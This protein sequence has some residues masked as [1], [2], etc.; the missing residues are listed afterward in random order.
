MKLPDST[1]TAEATD[2]LD[3]HSYGI[4][5]ENMHLAYQ[6]FTQYS[7]PISSI[8]REV[9]SNCVDAHDE[10]RMIRDGDI[11][12]DDY[13]D[14]ETWDELKSRLAG[15]EE[16]M[17]RI[18]ISEKYPL[19]DERWIAFHDKG[20]GLSPNR[21]EKIYSRFF[22]SNKRD[23]NDLIGAF[24][25]GSKSPLSYCD[26]FDVI[27]RYNGIEYH[28]LV[29]EEEHAPRIDL[30][31]KEPTEKANG[32][33]VRV[34]IESSRDHSKF[35][36]ACRKQLA[37]FE[38]LYF[39]GGFTGLG[40]M[41]DYTLH[42]G[43]N[44]MY[45]P[46]NSFDKLHI[47]L[48]RV[49]YP[50]NFDVL[51]DVDLGYSYKSSGNHWHVPIALHFDV[52]ELDIVWNRESIEYTERTQQK[53]RDKMK[54]VVSEYERL[55]KEKYESISSFPEWIEA[56][57]NVSNNYMT[58]TEGTELPYSGN[59]LDV[60][61]IPYP[62]YT[63]H[64]DTLPSPFHMFEHHREIKGGYVN[65]KASSQNVN[66]TLHNDAQKCFLTRKHLKTQRNK[67]IADALGHQKFHLFK[68][69]S[70]KVLTEDQ[71]LKRKI[72]KSLMEGPVEEFNITGD[73]VQALLDFQQEAINYVFGKME[74]YDN[75]TVTEA[76][77]KKLREE[78]RRKREKKQK[79]QESGTFPAKTLQRG[80]SWRHDMTWKRVRPRWKNVLRNDTLIV[81]GH[82][83]DSDDL[84]EVGRIVR[85]MDITT[86]RSNEKLNGK[87]CRVLK[88][89]KSRAKY[90]ED[91]DN[92]YTAEEFLSGN[93]HI[94]D[95]LF[96]RAGNKLVAKSA[97]SMDALAELFPEVKEM[98][99]TL[100]RYTKTGLSYRNLKQFI[101]L[102]ETGFDN[103]ETYLKSLSDPELQHMV[104]ALKGYEIKYPLV[105]HLNAYNVRKNKEVREELTD[106]AETKGAISPR[107]TYRYTLHQNT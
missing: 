57:N 95:R 62:K 65:Q 4:D 31:S 103:Y 36:E 18:E 98:Q 47:C 16:D 73:Q 24:G 82:R 23:T 94:I 6:A 100:K 80:G 99:E 5:E 39:E 64:L 83:A 63:Q 12:K 15:W 102:D 79:K 66:K 8:V 104:N 34:P 60:K 49:Y 74:D 59:L 40:D 52:G 35:Q 33:T 90:F 67:Y 13:D 70:H 91:L 28:W 50:I 84:E 41:N 29:Y 56:K 106:Y 87:K 48:G 71:N 19:N 69:N 72:S 55:F 76:Y 14:P 68:F 58:T 9:T 85:E 77:K 32:T 22:S 96:R 42:R 78:R 46:D 89:A 10:A 27:T 45:R 54:D 11:T 37:Y 88:I 2:E 21:I 17:V 7:D 26:M 51:D 53:I 75:T 38:N 107:L 97:P 3:G 44:F 1:H 101:D 105:A 61:Q 20:L 43:E 93:C 86:S 30:T 92:A 25:L 81:Y